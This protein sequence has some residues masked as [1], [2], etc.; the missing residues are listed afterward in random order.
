MMVEC[1]RSNMIFKDDLLSTGLFWVCSDRDYVIIQKDAFRVLKQFVDCVN[2]T[3]KFHLYLS[4]RLTT[5]TRGVR[6]EGHRVLDVSVSDI[7]VHCVL[8]Y[9]GV[10]LVAIRCNNDH[11]LYI[12][13]S[14]QTLEFMGSYSSL[15]KT[16]HPE[17]FS[18]VLL[19]LVG[20]NFE[21]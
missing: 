16:S 21:L 20:V 7:C 14:K 19:C 2:L 17:V 1:A 18:P 3:I 13:L 11:M 15:G 12:M 10:L 4:T 5:D 9:G 6:Y 8:G